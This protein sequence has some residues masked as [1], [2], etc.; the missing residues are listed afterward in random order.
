MSVKFSCFLT[1]VTY[2]LDLQ[3]NLVRDI[4]YSSL[5]P[6]LPSLHP[7]ALAALFIPPHTLILISDF[8]YFRNQV[9]TNY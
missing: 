1:Q 3:P 9:T 4:P 5:S 6:S 8:V 7:R 2:T